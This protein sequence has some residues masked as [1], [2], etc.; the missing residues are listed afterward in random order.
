MA[1]KTAKKTAPKKA[2]YIATAKVMGKTFT[3]KGDSIYKA[4]E[5]IKPG[6]VAG[7]VFISVSNGKDT[8]ERVVSMVTARRLF[9][10]VGMT[11]E[12]SI[13]N[14]SLMFDGI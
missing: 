5:A 11:R 10:T 7:M 13:K 6:A 12:V 4:I 3:G 8:K 1:K 14:M 2:N 9:M